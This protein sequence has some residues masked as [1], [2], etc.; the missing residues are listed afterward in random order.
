MAEATGKAPRLVYGE[1]G[2]HVYGGHVSP[3]GGMLFTGNMRED[4]DP[5]N[6]GAPMGLMRLADAPIIG[7]ESRELRA[8]HPKVQDGPVLELPIGWEPCWTFAELLGSAGAPPA[9][10]GTPASQSPPP[11]SAAGVKELASSI[12]FG[13]GAEHGPRAR[14][15]PPDQVA[16]LAAELHD[17]GWLV[18]SA[19][20]SRRLGP[21][22]DAAGRL[23]SP[24]DHRHAR[25]QRRRRT[26][27]RDGTRLLYYR[28]PKSEPDNNTYGTFDLVFADANGREP[29]VWGKAYP[30]VSWGPDGKQLA[31]LAPKGIQILGRGHAPDRAA[32]PAPRHREPVDLVTGRTLLRRYG[33]RPAVLEHRLPQSGTRARSTPS[34]T[35]LQLH[36]RL[37]PDAQHIVYAR[38]IIPQ[39]PGHAELWV[40]NADGTGTRRLF[41]DP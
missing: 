30:W 17:R 19:N 33:E 38:G 39:Q 5:A 40:A 14:V 10:A 6:A 15:R 13:E 8:L 18:F 12:V 41:A 31:C 36:A 28:M 27:S 7:G 25:V 4:G 16:A 3:D 32:N 34:E 20:S 37:T 1:D 9:L 29:Q 2:R 23:G 26:F 24:P 21:V 11:Q 22:P 35:G